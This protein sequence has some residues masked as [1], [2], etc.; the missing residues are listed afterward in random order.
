MIVAPDPINTYGDALLPGLTYAIN[1][2]S[3]SGGGW[4]T[5]L[6]Q[7]DLLTTHFRYGAQILNDPTL[8]FTPN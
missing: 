4:D 8:R 3:E 1:N 6:R 7:R 5:V 2:A